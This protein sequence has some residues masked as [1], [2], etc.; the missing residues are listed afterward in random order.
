MSGV[1]IVAALLIA[2]GLVGIVVPVLPGSILVLV[3]IALWATEQGGTT[4]WLVLVAAAALV[5]VGTVVKYLVPGRRLQLSGVPR[6]TLV[7][8]TLL[9]IV[10]FFVIPVIGLVIG[11]VLGVYAGEWRRT[12]AAEALPTTVQALK[13]VG[14]GILV[15]LFFAVLAT[16]VW[17]GGVVAT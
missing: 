2:V 5:G 7:F 8:A 13:A 16:L 12:S 11:F 3:A 14:L 4:A 9:A 15:E 6:S 17:V 1:E 10:G